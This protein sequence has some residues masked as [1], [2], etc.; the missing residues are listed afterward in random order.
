MLKKLLAKY[1]IFYGW[2]MVLVG[3]LI[4]GV[5]YGTVFNCF[6]LF[7][8]PVS[9]GMGYTRQAFATSLTII[10]IFFTIISVFSGKIFQKIKLH[11]VMC[12][13]AVVLP[14]AYFCNSLCTKIWQ[15][16]VL[17]AVQGICI[18]I[19]SFT[20]FSIIIANW[21][22]DRRGLAMGF[23]FMGSGFGGFVLNLLAST[24]LANHG[25][26]FAFRVLGIIMAAVLVPLVF[27]VLK[28]SPEDIG[29]KAL[30]AQ[31]N[32]EGG[33]SV[34]LY[35]PMLNKAMGGSNFWL[36][37]MT[38]I[39]IGFTASTL[40]QSITP[41]IT[42]CGFD[43]VYAARI[44]AGYFGFLCFC[45][46]T[47]GFA[48]DK[49]GMKPTTIIA[50]LMVAL[51]LVALYFGTYKA[52]HIFVILG[53]GGCAAG[54]VALPMLTQ[55]ACGNRDF[56]SINGIVTAGNTLGGALCPFITN[57]IYDAKGSYNVALLLAVALI[58]VTILLILLIRVLKKDAAAA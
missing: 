28:V 41:H 9:E 1:N 51:G 42:D 32:K 54:S 31:E 27:F 37:V 57:A 5:A 16:Y 15:F 43:P 53:S 58:A 3:I 29:M 17:A 47:M 10:F 50:M 25:F 11:T 40:A 24:W 55:A 14:I 18:P 6:S 52:A 8:I 22:E 26:A 44:N 56:S 7:T 39:L 38:A 4:M 12:I 46:I 23:T 48:Y 13:C 20:A 49:L 45:K 2:F 33:A 19:L 36:V 34:E 35:G 30:G 21:F